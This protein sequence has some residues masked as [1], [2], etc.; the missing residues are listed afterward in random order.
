MC[1]VCMT[2]K[3]IMVLYVRCQ[4]SFVMVSAYAL[5]WPT[6]LVLKAIRTALGSGRNDWIQEKSKVV[7]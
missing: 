5:S 4:D 2:T 6:C 1:M 3:D 7:Q